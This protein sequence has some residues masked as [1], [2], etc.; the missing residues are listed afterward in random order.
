MNV[1][2]YEVVNVRD[3][4]GTG[5][6]QT[7]WGIRV[8]SMTMYGYIYYKKRHERSILAIFGLF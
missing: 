3:S 1:D 4:G 7:V 5:V 8:T 6:Q 2:S